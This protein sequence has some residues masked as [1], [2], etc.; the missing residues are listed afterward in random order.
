MTIVMTAGRDASWRERA[1]TLAVFMALGLSVGTWAAAMPALKA[2]FALDAAGLSLMLLALSIASVMATVTMG[3]VVPRIGTAPA[4][5]LAA[6]AMVASVGLPGLAQTYGQ[7][8]ASGAV[9]GF[10]AGSLEVAVNGHASGIEHRWGSSIMSSFHAAFSIGGLVGAVLGGVVSW[11]GAG[12]QGQLWLPL[13][14]GAA[15]VIAARPA[16]GPGVKNEPGPPAPFALPGR[17]LLFLSIVAMLSYLLEGALADWSA[18]YLTSVAGAAPWI[19]ASGYAAFS[20]TMAISRLTGDGIVNRLGP[21]RVVAF[22]GLLAAG[23]LSLAVLVPSPV[24][25]AIGFAL[26][27]IG[28]ANSVPVVFSQ[29]GRMAATPAAGIATVSTCGF[30]GFVGGPPAIGALATWAGLRVGF[31]ALILATLLIA[32]AAIGIRADQPTARRSRT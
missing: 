18:V 2:A 26:V 9:I 17:A 27:G 13:L 15:L 12:L 7:L 21:Q 20:V 24:P 28:A 29:A 31:G 30:A 1:A 22:G 11:A 5:V 8:L 4:T 10:A 19:A 6:I 32:V 3:F 16:L 25:V 23:G 14:G